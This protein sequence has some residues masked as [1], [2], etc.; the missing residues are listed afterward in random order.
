MRAIGNVP[1]PRLGLTVSCA[2]SSDCSPR[3]NPLEGET[4]D[5]RLPYCRKCG[6]TGIKSI[7]GSADR[8]RRPAVCISRDAHHVSAHAE[9]ESAI[10]TLLFGREDGI[11]K[12]FAFSL[13]AAVTLAQPALSVA[14]DKPSGCAANSR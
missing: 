13:L 11:M 5:P 8:G 10:L 1:P 3:P 6:T 9:R 7:S 2:P 14:G 12:K 4:M